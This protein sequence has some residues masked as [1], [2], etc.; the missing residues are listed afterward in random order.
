MTEAFIFVN[1]FLAMTGGVENVA[2]FTQGVL[3]AYP[4]TGLYDLILKVKAADEIR[5][6]EVLHKIKNIPGVAATLTSII[7]MK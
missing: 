1:C 4:T 2:K 6:Q 7:Y 5:L 3:E